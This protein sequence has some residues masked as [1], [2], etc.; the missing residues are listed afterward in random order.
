MRV[1]GIIRG[2]DNGLLATTSLD[3]ID[4][5]YSLSVKQ[6]ASAIYS[7][8]GICWMDSSMAIPFE[9]DYDKPNDVVK[10]KS[11]YRL[12]FCNY[13][14]YNKYYLNIR[15]PGTTNFLCIPWLKFNDGVTGVAVPQ[16][17]EDIFAH[18]PNV[19]VF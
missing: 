4:I 16:L 13:E 9:F 11:E 14:L 6:I 8:S 10:F 3:N 15:Y 17:I 1:S 18:I 19:I 2:V 5:S 12:C 7:I